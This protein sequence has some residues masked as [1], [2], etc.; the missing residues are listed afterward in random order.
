MSLSRSV[1]TFSGVFPELFWT[2]AV[3]RSS[4]KPVFLEIFQNS[5]ENICARVSILI[6]KFIEIEALVQVFL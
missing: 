2:E 5:Q 6:N 1:K 3:G 4:V